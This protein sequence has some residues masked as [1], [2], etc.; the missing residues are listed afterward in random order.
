MILEICLSS[1]TI[2]A[3]EEDVLFGE[4]VATPVVGLEPTI[5]ARI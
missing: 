5:R 2:Q 3:L 4:F 1:E